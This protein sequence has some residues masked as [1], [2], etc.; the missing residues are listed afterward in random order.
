M[1]ISS[2]HRKN[3]RNK[4]HS[5]VAKTNANANNGTWTVMHVILNHF[6]K[7]FRVEMIHFLHNFKIILSNLWTDWL[8]L[9]LLQNNLFLRELDRGK[10]INYC[11]KISKQGKSMLMS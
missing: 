7:S 5:S 3:A 2:A 10:E 11:W 4:I 1:R 6:W 9:F 8:R